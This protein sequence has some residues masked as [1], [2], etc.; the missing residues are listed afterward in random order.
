MKNTLIIFLLNFLPIFN[1][2]QNVK[3][4]AVTSSG[5]S[6]NQSNAKI[7]FT[8]GE[9]VVKT[10]TDGTN[11]I[12]QGVVNSSTSNIITA[13]RETDITKIK[14]NVYPNPAGDLV[15]I[16]IFESKVAT[17]QLSIYDISGKQ[18]SSEKYIAGNN[19]IGINTQSWQEGNYII[20]INDI[21]GELLGSYKISKQ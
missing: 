20:V 17:I 21:A 14:M 6:M 2:A 18:I 4:S 3:S 7:S 12:G 13:I 19:H 5:S 1:Y 15:Y 8:V 9:I 11:S 10:I 16:D